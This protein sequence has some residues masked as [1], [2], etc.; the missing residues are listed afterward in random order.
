MAGSMSWTVDT[1]GCVIELDASDG[2]F[3][4]TL[5][6]CD[7][8]APLAD[9]PEHLAAVLLH[10]RNRNQVTNDILADLGFGGHD[11]PPELEL[12][13]DGDIIVVKGLQAALER[14][15]YP[16]QRQRQIEQKLN[17]KFPGRL[18]FDNG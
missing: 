7:L 14:M 17:N 18:R 16:S 11:I 5:S 13:Y 8:H 6:A 12:F 10:N 3:K 4:S 1:C 9:T 15:G 2:S